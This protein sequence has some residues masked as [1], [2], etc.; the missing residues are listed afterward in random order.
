MDIRC[1][2]TLQSGPAGFTKT[3]LR[4]LGMASGAG[5]SLL[6][7][8]RGL[9]SYCQVKTENKEIREQRKYISCAIEAARF[10]ITKSSVEIE[11]KFLMKIF[12]NDKR[13]E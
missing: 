2:Y 3:E 12:S 8:F 7:L 11:P 9:I 13:T 4:G 10:I 5:E 1:V 6:G